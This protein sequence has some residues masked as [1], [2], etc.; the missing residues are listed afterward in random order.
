LIWPFKNFFFTY[1]FFYLTVQ[2]HFFN[3]LFF[4]LTEKNLF[5]TNSNILIPISLKIW[6]CGKDS[7][8]FEINWKY[9]LLR[10]FKN[11]SAKS[12]FDLICFKKQTDEQI[13]VLSMDW[14]VVFHQSASNNAWKFIIQN[15][16]FLYSI[17]LFLLQT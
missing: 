15:W 6:V 14:H 4:Y 12:Y 10:P 2:K 3:I 17:L 7:I 5:A 16:L 9:F 8:R 1:S 13:F 11:L